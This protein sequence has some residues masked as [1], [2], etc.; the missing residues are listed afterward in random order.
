MFDACFLAWS[1]GC[2]PHHSAE[3]I[4]RIIL[5]GVWPFT[6][7]D[8]WIRAP[9]G[10]SSVECGHRSRQW[11]PD[12][13]KRTGPKFSDEFSEAEFFGF[14]KSYLSEAFP[15]PPAELAAHRIPNYS[16]WL[17][18]PSRPRDTA[19]SE[20][21]TCCSAVL[22]TLHGNTWRSKATVG[23]RIVING[24]CG[25]RTLVERESGTHFRKLWAQTHSPRKPGIM[26]L[27]I[28]G[29][30]AQQTQLLFP[31]FWMVMKV[32]TAHLPK[33]RAH[34]A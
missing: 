20:H 28:I 33:P 22:Q 9:S 6:V 15:N 4:L 26:S 19:A 23:L 14:A 13:D 29:L 8:R 18:I 17:N 10:T 16:A 11:T 2:C 32:A 25:T 1:C 30:H 12:D 21:L 24:G 3:K 31:C 34:R 7:A 5:S 27:P